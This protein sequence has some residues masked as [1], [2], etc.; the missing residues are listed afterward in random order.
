MQPV[1]PPT[2]T[3]HPGHASVPVWVREH[4]PPSCGEHIAIGRRPVPGCADWLARTLITYNWPVMCCAPHPPSGRLWNKVEQWTHRE[5]G[6]ARFVMYF[7]PPIKCF[8]CVVCVWMCASVYVC[9]NAWVDVIAA[10]ML[11]TWRCSVFRFW[12][13]NSVPSSVTGEWLWACAYVQHE[14]FCVCV[15]VN[16]SVCVCVQFISVCVWQFVWQQDF[17]LTTNN[18]RRN[19]YSSL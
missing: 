7:W 3:P 11:T 10:A 13:D 1:N 17:Y 8:L 16:F 5:E 19:R 18:W 2:P 9:E 15:T 14:G 4:P 12:T 6:D